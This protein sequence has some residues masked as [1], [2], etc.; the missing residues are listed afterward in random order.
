MGSRE[1]NCYCG[2]NRERREDD[3]TE[4]TN[5]SRLIQI[6]LSLTDRFESEMIRTINFYIC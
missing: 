2:H 1:E 4:P 5:G 6:S 3:Q